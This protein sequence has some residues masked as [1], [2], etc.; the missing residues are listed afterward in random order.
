[1]NQGCPVI[2]SDRTSLREV[3]G[4]AA[5]YIDPA[6]P[7]QI[8]ATMLQLEADTRLRKKLI[9]ASQM[10]AATFSWDQTARQTLDFYQTLSRA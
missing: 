10:Q 2:S 4:E 3:G 9:E 5:L 1:M 7:R 8:A 6:N